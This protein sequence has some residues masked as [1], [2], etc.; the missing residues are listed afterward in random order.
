M[1]TRLLRYFVALAE[2]LHFGRAAVRLSISQP[3]LSVAIKQLE[4]QV[5][6]QLFERNSKEVRLTAAGEHLLPRAKQILTLTSQ[7]A[8]ET[9]DVARGVRGHL[10][11]G[12]VGSSLY[13]GVPQALEAFQKLHPQVRVDMLEL[14]SAEQLQELQQARLDLGLVH[15]I[16]P[17]EDIASLKLMDEAFMACL[18]DQHPLA[19]QDVIDLAELKNERLI[20]FLSQVSPVYHQRIYQMCQTHGFAP[21]I[22]HEVRHW[23]SVLSLVSLGQGVAI[24]PASLQRVGMP[25]VA[26]SRLVGD[27]ATSELLAV[28]RRNPVN[29]LVQSLLGCLQAAIDDIADQPV[30]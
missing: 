1:E 3:P 9:T 29:P 18:P 10:R 23:L 21:E 22:R 24:V 25:R 16:Q 5:Q 19:Q 7:A 17:P 30:D 6:A 8:Q 15:S 11:V 26:F 4:D 14:N 12:F 27:Q 2:E 13:R 20:L 28:W